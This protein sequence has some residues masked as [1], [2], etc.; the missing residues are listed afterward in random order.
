[1]DLFNWIR[2]SRKSKRTSKQQ[3]QFNK[4]EER[5]KKNNN[6]A[7]DIDTSDV[8]S[9]ASNTV[10]DSMDELDM[11]QFSSDYE[12]EKKTCS[13]IQ[14]PYH[15]ETDS[16]DDEIMLNMNLYN[17]SLPDNSHINMPFLENHPQHPTHQVHCVKDTN[18]IVP[19]FM[20]GALP[21]RDHGDQEY[22][23]LTMLVLFKP[24]RS[25]KD[26]KKVNQTWQESFKEYKFSD[27]QR[28]LMDNFNI[29]YECNDARD[30]YSAKRQKDDN[31]CDESLWCDTNDANDVIDIENNFGDDDRAINDDIEVYTI[32]NVKHLNK[33]GQIAEIEN[34][35]HDAGW[36]RNR[37]ITILYRPPG[38]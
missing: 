5:L 12:Y 1:M 2:L 30:D 4:N 11:F 28:Q 24:W 26:L 8:E 22:Y 35:I 14:T 32:P 34:I 6:F 37:K 36:H 38:I 19:N 7:M 33:L 29:R 25:G 13:A 23:C 18:K 20:N 21:R 17:E 3:Q 31:K 15:N 16:S 27:R 10:V 9:E